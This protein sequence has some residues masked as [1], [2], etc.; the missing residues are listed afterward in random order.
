M[1]KVSAEEK[2][3]KFVLFSFFLFLQL[4]RDQNETWASVWNSRV[5]V[6]AV[7]MGNTRRCY[8][9]DVWEE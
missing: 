4:I 6:S 3:F 5:R 1:Y 9:A 2:I 7:G 8:S